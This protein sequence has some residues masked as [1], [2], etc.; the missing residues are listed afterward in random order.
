[1][2]END[3]FPQGTNPAENM[4]SIAGGDEFTFQVKEKMHNLIDSLFFE[5]MK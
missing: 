2:V 3:N 5:G 4:K 1:M